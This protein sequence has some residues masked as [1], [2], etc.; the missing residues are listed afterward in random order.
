VAR[1]AF[2]TLATSTILGIVLSTLVVASSAAPANAGTP[3]IVPPQSKYESG[4]Y[5]VTLS[6]DSAATYAG[7]IAG[8]KATRPHSGKQLRAQDQ[9]VRKYT[10]YLRTKQ[11][12][13]ASTVGAHV[14][15]HYS[16]AYNGFAASLSGDEAAQLAAT[17]GVLAVVR[18]FILPIQSAPSTD[19]LGI[20]GANGAWNQVG[21]A[22]N[23]GA[24]VVVGMID[25]GIAP[26]NPSFAGTPLDTAT[27]TTTPW[28]NSATDR[29]NFLKSD[30]GTFVGTR[31]V[32]DEFSVDDYSTKLVGARYFD[33]GFVETGVI[34]SHSDG[35]YLSP[36]DGDGHGSHTAST[37]VGDTAVAAS[38]GALSLGTIAGIAPA[39]KLAVYK[40]CWTAPPGQDS[41]CA[42][43][44]IIAA[45]D[46][47]VA[48]GVDVLSYSIAGSP[49]TTTYSPIDAAFLGAA[50][51]GIFVS[52]A[53]GNAGP[54]AS[55]LD[56]AAPWETTV[57]ATSTALSSHGP[58]PR[59]SSFS[60]RGPV[61]AAGGDVLKPDIA[62]PG[63]YIVAAMAN[64]EGAPPTWG[65]LS[66]TSMATPQI[67][68]LA[69]IYLGV[70]PVASPAEVKSALMTTAT[71]TVTSSGHAMTNP[72][73]QGA[74]RVRANHFLHPTLLYLSDSD[75]WKSYLVGTG[76]A[77]FVGI[78][79][80]DPSDLN[81][82]SISIGHLSG[83]QTVTR[84][85]TAAQAGTYTVSAVMPGTA[86]TVA[87]KTLK[88]DSVG[89]AKT[90]TVTISRTTAQLGHWATGYLRWTR[91][92]GSAISRIPIAVLPSRITAPTEISADGTSGTAEYS[93]QKGTRSTVAI[94]TAGLA[95]RVLTPNNADPDAEFTGIADAN[96]V[97]PYTQFEHVI[98]PGTKFAR[99]EIDAVESPFTD[100]DL[101][102]YRCQAIDDC[103]EVGSST[104]P[105]AHEIV[106]V[107][108]PAA[109]TYF[110]VIDYFATPVGGTQ[111]SEFTYLLDPATAEG[112]FVAV[113]TSI[114][115]SAGTQRQVA[116]R[117][118]GLQP[119]ALY[120]G[121]VSYSGTKARTFVTVTTDD[122]LA[123]VNVSLPQVAPGADPIPGAV[124]SALPGMWDA[125]NL[126]YTYQW[127][128]DGI[129]VDGAT[130][131]TF[132][133]PPA[134][135][136]SRLSVEVTATLPFAAPVTS[137]TSRAL[138]IQFV[139]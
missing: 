69:A 102:V 30:G 81:L 4:T 43:T 108:H 54:Y 33:A 97:V 122:A 61:L 46:A 2:R 53:A 47:A 110:S 106:D 94:S 83:S 57:A 99:F 105:S 89:E 82:P 75:D 134:T 21:G 139:K 40:A 38:V 98:A 76:Q 66:G 35:E 9:T 44:D 62:A 18:N 130:D 101:Y 128:L 68:G 51:A 1:F 26:E 84:T 29:V 113:P 111:F 90:F 93:M 28:F 119:H 31:T 56:N 65:I 80:I 58:F 138:V 41:G 45:I 71:N 85:V 39:A 121:V 95:P 117:W 25:T 3:R 120:L 32:G 60:G 112:N 34:G 24:G 16:L 11:S 114:H 48:D 132:T 67:S 86:I 19:Y 49:A 87:P 107:S 136:G 59:I 37:A 63:E 27:S 129:E 135:S 5:L 64:A 104:S 109:G 55:S 116:L 36:R 20:R 131:S 8:L 50:E 52:V 22:P 125:P 92:A 126:T 118:G 79:A 96:A 88:F 124:V 133:I 10:A 14:L 7:G 103:V 77:E 73:A 12:R 42:L 23:A 70:H 74:G 127:L 6:N 72:F 13:V 17:P 91:T 123:P 137:A 15:Y 115:G 100:L 78:A